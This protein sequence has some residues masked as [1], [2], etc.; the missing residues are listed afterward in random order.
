M[1]KQVASLKTYID[2]LPYK[3]E[4]VDEMQAKLEA[5]VGKI[6]ICAKSKNWAVLSTWDGV[7]QWYT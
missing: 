1:E 6:V 4:L 5:I 2:A 3:C 7:L